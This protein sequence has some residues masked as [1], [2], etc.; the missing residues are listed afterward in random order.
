MKRFYPWL[1]AFTLSTSAAYCSA[2]GYGIFDARSLAMGGTGVALGNTANGF[3]Y[4][5][6]HMALA[7][8]SKN[9]TKNSTLYVPSITAEVTEGARTAEKINRQSL[10]QALTQAILLFNNSD[11]NPEN[12]AK[13][14]EA[15]LAIRNAIDQLDQRP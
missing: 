15:A 7:T 3:Y 14:L 5:P 12:A 4:N 11:F 13:G 9:K 8:K 2:A 6:A 10:D 1:S